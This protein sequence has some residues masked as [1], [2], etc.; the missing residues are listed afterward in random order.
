MN[1]SLADIIVCLMCYSLGIRE[2]N[3]ACF[4][5]QLLSYVYLHMYVQVERVLKEGC[6]KNLS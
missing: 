4:F 3:T 5:K 1:F 6:A 2:M